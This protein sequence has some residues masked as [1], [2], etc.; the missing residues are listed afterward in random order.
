MHASSQP[1]PDVCGFNTAQ[2]VIGAGAAGLVAARELLR[3]G[4]RPTVF[5]QGSRAGGVWVYTEATEEGAHGEAKQAGSVHSSMYRHLRTNLPREVMSYADFPFTRVWR[6]GRRFCGH[7]EVRGAGLPA[8]SCKQGSC[9][10]VCHQ[11]FYK[12]N[13]KSLMCLPCRWRPTWRRL[14]ITMTCSGM[15]SMTQG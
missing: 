1:T 13:E 3:E 15:C 10:H 6:D 2:C 11:S 8:M 4:H 14:Q 12:G 7:E 9:M 5:E